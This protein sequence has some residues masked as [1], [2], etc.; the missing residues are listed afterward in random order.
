[1]STARRHSQVGFSRIFVVVVDAE[2][3]K[4][5]DGSERGERNVVVVD[6]HQVGIALLDDLL[7]LQLQDAFRLVA[8][9]AADLLANPTTNLRRGR[10]GRRFGQT[11]AAF[12]SSRSTFVAAELRRE[13][14]SRFNSSANVSTT[15]SIDHGR[16]FP[17]DSLGRPSPSREYETTNGQIRTAGETPLAPRSSGL[18]R[19]RSTDQQRNETNFTNESLLALQ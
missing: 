10:V 13:T 9:T 18:Q 16:R 17:S 8:R 2:Q 19:F 3:P 5:T 15:L 14:S 12:L 6:E 1:M 4:R 11:G 7:D